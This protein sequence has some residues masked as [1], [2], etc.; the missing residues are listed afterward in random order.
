MTASNVIK[1]LEKATVVHHQ[2]ISN[3]VHVAV[4]CREV[5]GDRGGQYE[6]GKMLI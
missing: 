1:D 6:E 3:A 2:R 4:D 5:H